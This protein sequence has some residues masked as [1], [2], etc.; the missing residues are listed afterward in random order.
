MRLGLLLP[1]TGSSRDRGAIVGAATLA[2]GEINRHPGG[3]MR[4]RRVEFAYE[5]EG[6]SAM[7][8][9]T[10]LSRLLQAVATEPIHAVIG[11]SCS[12]ACLPSGYLA[13][14]SNLPQIS[15]GCTSG[16]KQ[17]VSCAHP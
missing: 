12:A 14:G 1:I 9:M 17:P 13:S 7:Q 11:A 10:G 6:C 3:L 5:D 15:N 4:G 16:T 8:G 2:I